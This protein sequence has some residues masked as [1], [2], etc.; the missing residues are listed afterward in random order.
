MDAYT[1]W[2]ECPETAEYLCYHDSYRVETRQ[3]A[4]GKIASIVS[5]GQPKFIPTK[6]WAARGGKQLV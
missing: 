1:G 6:V 4:E 5:H 3:P 2:T